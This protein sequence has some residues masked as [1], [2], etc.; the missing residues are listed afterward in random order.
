MRGMVIGST[1]RRNEKGIQDS[2]GDQKVVQKG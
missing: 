2:E 1:Y